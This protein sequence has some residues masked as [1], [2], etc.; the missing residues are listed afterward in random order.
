MKAKQIR[1]LSPEELNQKEKNLKKDL[2]ELNF[3]RKLGNVEKPARFRSI[4]RDIARI[5][6]ILNEK[7]KS[8]T[9]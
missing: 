4:K 3:Q 9:K 1:E 6:T 7:E 8:E 5:Q 2:F